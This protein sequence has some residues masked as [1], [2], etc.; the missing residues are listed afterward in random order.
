MFE[1]EHIVKYKQADERIRV[2]RYGSPYYNTEGS[3]RDG[4]VLIKFT[5]EKYARE[6]DQH[7]RD[8]LFDRA[9]KIGAQFIIQGYRGPQIVIPYLLDGN[10]GLFDDYEEN[11]QTSWNKEVNYMAYLDVRGFR[12]DRATAISCAGY[13]RRD[14]H[15]MPGS[16]GVYDVATGKKITGRQNI[17]Q[18][19]WDLGFLGNRGVVLYAADYRDGSPEDVLRYIQVKPMLK[20]LSWNS[21]LVKGLDLGM[22][23]ISRACDWPDAIR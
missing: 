6:E 17:L 5:V 4:D 20:T 13:R 15:V 18:R 1:F 16:T 23:K 10:A 14:G 19:L 2:N 9:R 21:P 22:T 3:S 12:S 11:F 7:N 8:I